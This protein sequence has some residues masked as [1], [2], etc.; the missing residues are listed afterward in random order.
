MKSK[1]IALIQ[2][3][4]SYNF[5]GAVIFTVYS[6]NPLPAAMLAYMAGIPKRL[7]L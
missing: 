3:I 2:K 7:G 4:R 1:L 6:Q 5:D